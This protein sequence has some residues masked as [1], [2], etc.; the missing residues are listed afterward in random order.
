MSEKNSTTSSQVDAI[1]MWRCPVCGRIISEIE[2]SLVKFDFD[3]PGKLS[4][5]VSC[6]KKLSGY[7]CKAI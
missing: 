3:C 4:N 6:Y 5:G 7:I 1:V 2:M